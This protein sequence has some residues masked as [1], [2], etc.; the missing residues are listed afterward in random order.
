MAKRFTDSTIWKTQR[1][2]KKLSPIYKLAWKYI[3]D[4]CDHA[5]V[6]KIDYCEFIDDLGI[7]EIDITDFIKCCNTDYDKATGKVHQKDRILLIR[8]NVFWITGFIRFQYEGKEQILNP[9]TPVIY[10]ALTVL[11]GYGQFDEGLSKGYYTLSQPYIK[12]MLT[13]KDK[14]KDKVIIDNTLTVKQTENGKIKPIVN[15]KAQG[16]ELFA[17][18]FAKGENKT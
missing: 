4:T 11:V 6:L 7:E 17:K 10:S 5:G 18:R 15:F 16:E 2:F 3:T 8:D 13:T 1:W 12:G 14:D 9:K